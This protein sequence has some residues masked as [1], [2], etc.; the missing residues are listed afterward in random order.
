MKRGGRQG[1][2]GLG[3]GLSSLLHDGAPGGQEAEASA[4]GALPVGEIK[5]N[6]YQPRRDFDD[7]ALGELADSIRQH[8]LV[9]PI[10]VR[11]A[12][13]GQGY[14]LIAGE[15][16]WRA[17]Q[18]A[19]LTAVP[20]VV[21]EST[22]REMVEMALVENL[23]REDLNPI[24]AAEAYRQ[25]I[26]EFALTQEDLAHRVGKSRT[27]VTN[28]LR[29]LKLAEPVRRMI[30]DG[31]LTEGHAR[32]LLGLVD[33]NHHVMVAKRVVTE[34]LTVRQTEALVRDLKEQAAG[35]VAPEPSPPAKP[36]PS[37]DPDLAAFAQRLERALGNRLEIK[38]R[39][40]GGGR[41][42][43]HYDTVE[44]LERIA[45]ALGS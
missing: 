37:L 10:V 31:R 3:R 44:D 43:I 18:R 32:P 9:Q 38:P 7:A 39:D 41:V 29:L 19:G 6:P 26:D 13:D 34:G 1:R 2:S 33:E 24:E 27:T 45:E 16:R 35:G 20:A 22:E 25:I 8:G 15:R 40:K 17:A 30:A 23:Q 28:T 11:P 36:T 4:G 21:R 14:Q 5:P 12:P 42:V